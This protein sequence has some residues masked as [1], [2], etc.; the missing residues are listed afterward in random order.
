[1]SSALDAAPATGGAPDALWLVVRA[2]G[3][4]DLVLLSAAIALGVAAAGR[5]QGRRAPRFVRQLVHR[6]L[7]LL[8]V[9]LLVAHV[10]AA[11]AL[12]H[13]GA[14]A[15]LVPF[16]SHVRRGYLGLGVL[17]ADLMVLLT[18]TSVVRRRMGLEQWRRLHWA[19]YGAWVAAVVHGAAPGTDRLV[20]WVAWVDV[21]C[22]VIVAAAIAARLAGLAQHRPAVLVAGGATVAATVFIFTSWVHVAAPSAAIHGADAGDAPAGE[23]R[24]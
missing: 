14:L 17:G 3:T 4:V 15:S 10:L 12:L 5:G 9:G 7:A 23:V 1:M 11:V 22:V 2:A 8:A 20:P 24:R 21:A 18:V 6:D 13:L 19:A 16:T